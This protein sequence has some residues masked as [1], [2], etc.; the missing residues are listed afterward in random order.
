MRMYLKSDG[1]A[2]E[3]Q[4][5]I[6]NNFYISVLDDILFDCH[7][8]LKSERKFIKWVKRY[9]QKA[10]FLFFSESSRID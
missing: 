7:F 5:R 4:I 10:L 1:K 3:E 8:H 2:A 6:F 9:V